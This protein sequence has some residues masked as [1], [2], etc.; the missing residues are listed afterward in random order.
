MEYQQALSRL[1]PQLIGRFRRAL[2][3]GRWPDGEA[4]S[5]VQKAHCMQAIIAYEQTHL[6]ESD[7]VGYIDRGIKE[8]PSVDDPALTTITWADRA[9][10]EG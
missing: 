5:D 3:L 2:E 1:S 7:R 9:P 4:V 6:Q 8:G 10:N